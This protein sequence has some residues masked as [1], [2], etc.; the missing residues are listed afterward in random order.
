MKLVQLAFAAFI[1][2]SGISY[3]AE[4]T[5]G[6]IPEQNVF[7]QMKRYKPLGK[8]LEEKTN[9][10]I[11]FTILSRYGNIIESFHKKNLDG[12]FWGSF[13]GAMA[14]EKLGIK[15]VA[16]PVNMDGTSTYHGYILVRKDSGIKNVADMKGKVIAFV[17]KA[18]TAGYIFPIAYFKKHG[19]KGIDTYFKEYYFTGSHDSAIHSVLN[20]KADIA[21]A[22]NT[23][24]EI[25]ARDDKRIKDELMIIARSPDVPSNGL[26]LRQNLA[27]GVKADIKETLLNMYKNPRGKLVLEKF[28]VVRF[29]ETTEADYAPVSDLA[30]SAGI[31]LKDYEYINE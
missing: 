31:S 30:E 16:R 28:G 13:T 6:L 4:L 7:K 18:T 26:G 11:N 9:N 12:A 8:Y 29:I 25:L 20:K 14:I 19:I 22:K 24:Y 15:P 27:Y 23:V 21:C 5:I 17:E 2:F 3:A 10:K 1:I